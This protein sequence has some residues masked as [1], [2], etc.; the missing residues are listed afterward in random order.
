MV[1]LPC[2]I[3]EGNPAGYLIKDQDI[4]FPEGPEASASK[5]SRAARRREEVNKV[6]KNLDS[7]IHILRKINKGGR[8][9]QR[10]HWP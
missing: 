1:S 5:G 3:L 6:R 10:E 8:K 7:T 4:Y 9:S 2:E